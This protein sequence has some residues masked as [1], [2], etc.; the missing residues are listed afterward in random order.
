MSKIAKLITAKQKYPTEY[1]ATMTPPLCMEY[2]QVE[3]RLLTMPAPDRAVKYRIKV[4]LGAEIWISEE[5]AKYSGAISEAVYNVKRAVV[6]EIF[7]EFRHHI[8]MMHIAL[9]D[10]DYD[11]ARKQLSELEDKMFREGL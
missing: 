7:G 4:E 1:V 11:K 10:R 3:D 6:E 2:A 5:A 8:T 9:Y